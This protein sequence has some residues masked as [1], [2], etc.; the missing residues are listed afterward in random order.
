[1]LSVAAPIDLGVIR[2]GVRR[3]Y[4]YRGHR[5]I[6]TWSLL[7]PPR[8]VLRRYYATHPEFL[9]DGDDLVRPV[10]PLDYRTELA[11]NDSILVDVLRS[12]PAC[13]LDRTSLWTECARRSMNN[14]TFSLYLTY[15]PVI[16]HLGTDIWSLRGVR[17]DPT[18]VE[19]LR[20]GNDLRQKEKS[21]LD[22]GWSASGKCRIF[23]SVP[24]RL[25][26]LHLHP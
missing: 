23:E 26:L 15:S 8:S 25:L 2:E 14:N 1:M 4:T 17:V 21:V 18:A 3:E 16:V 11:L 13:L 19:A 24:S 5:G 9:I 10:D 20:G 7:V 22:N 6:K 12:S